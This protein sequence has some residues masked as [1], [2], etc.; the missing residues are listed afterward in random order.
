[1]QEPNAL[2]GAADSGNGTQPMPRV[3]GRAVDEGSPKPRRDAWGGVWLALLL[4][5]AVALV[6]APATVVRAPSSLFLLKIAV[7]GLF[8]LIPG[9][10]YLVF[11]RNKGGSLYDEYVLNLFR[12]HIDEYRNLPAPPQHTS[13]Y[14]LWHKEHKRLNATT[15][16]N[17]YR[18][19]FE[20]VYG[21][22]A[23]STR[24]LI[25][26]GKRRRAFGHRTE[27][28]S[29]VLLATVVLSL[30]WVLV[31][32]PQGFPGVQLL[33][34]VNPPSRPD[35]PVDALR[36][37]FLGAYTFIL[38]DLARRYFR[39]DLK[40]AAFISSAVR[41]VIVAPLVTALGAAWPSQSAS[42]LNVLAF[43][44]G[45][46][47][48]V[49]FQA[50]RASLARGL[51]KV[52]PSLD[53]EYPL[54]QLDGLNVW[55][56][57]RLVE[58]GI[59]DMQ[60]LVSV[61][62]V[63]LLLHSRAPV[64]RLVDWIDQAALYL[65]LGPVK[66]GTDPSSRSRLRAMGIRTAT[67]LERA[68][69]VMRAD[70]TFARKLGEAVGVTDVGEARAVVRAICASLDGQVNLWHIRQFKGCEWLKRDVTPARAIA[71]V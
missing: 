41:I 33:G 29:P 51:R 22:D 30:G 56:E 48:Q 15:T 6:L 39:G 27:T 1:M 55:Y 24:E 11:I 35:L 31:L 40:T 46:F 20:T 21:P 44:V 7:A 45:F 28:F 70:D 62:L 52:I 71:G 17:L 34:D 26:K 37:G 42:Q 12:L 47:P 2:K 68:W 58:E 5:C 63:E 53:P 43:V 4:L 23:V 54:S 10:L 66:N 3:S 49:A 18:R 67:D 61:N 14:G 13:Y 50:I 38:Q 57:A 8:S 60:N 32:E 59:E 25:D 69:E 19:K 16:D 65:H 64:G 36:Y 9:W